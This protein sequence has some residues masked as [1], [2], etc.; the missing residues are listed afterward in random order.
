MII[1]SVNNGAI[2]YMMRSIAKATDL[3]RISLYRIFSKNNTSMVCAWNYGKA[4]ADN[5]ELLLPPDF[6]VVSGWIKT[7]SA[8]ECINGNT[9][10]MNE[11]DAV[12]L[13]MF[14]IKSIFFTPLIVDGKLWGVI[15]FEDHKSYRY[16]DRDCVNAFK[17]AGE[18][19]SGD[20]ARAHSNGLDV[21]GN[22][23]IIKKTVSV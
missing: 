14:G 13:C 10:H 23:F 6:R 9:A 5:D 3:D 2:S 16:F 1:N 8:G 21:Y 11:D 22:S 17:A 4:A 18:I 19:C 7:L 20:I 15:A 12:F